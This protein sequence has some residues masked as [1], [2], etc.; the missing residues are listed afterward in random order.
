MAS[1]VFL[2]KF[3]EIFTIYTVTKLWIGSQTTTLKITYLPEVILL[4]G[5][6]TMETTRFEI[7][8]KNERK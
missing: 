3:T 7:E 6:K 2:N 4:K 1:R 5:E 8:Y